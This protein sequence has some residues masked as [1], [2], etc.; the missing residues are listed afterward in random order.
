MRGRRT[1]GGGGCCCSNAGPPVHEFAVCW[2]A[3]ARASAVLF[4]QEFGCA[5]GVPVVGSRMPRA[6][7]MIGTV[8]V[9]VQEF[10]PA[11][12]TEGEW[13]F[14]F[15]RGTLIHVVKKRPAGGSS[16]FRVQARFGGVA[17]PAVASPEVRV[18]CWYVRCRMLRVPV[19]AI[20]RALVCAPAPLVRWVGGPCSVRQHHSSLNF[21]A[22]A[23]AA[24]V[25]R[26]PQFRS[27]SVLLGTQ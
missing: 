22:A 17:A 11:V 24:S 19:R 2:A 5:L 15:A 23:L 4:L 7:R 18:M 26:P 27:N 21:A 25:T 10:L 16:E 1:L 13:S 6:R 3:C 8:D 12:V 14:V 9:L 20:V